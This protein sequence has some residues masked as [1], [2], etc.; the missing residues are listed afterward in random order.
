[1][2]RL[3]N[4]L[5]GI[6][7]RPYYLHQLDR[8]RGTGHFHVPV[9]TGLAMMDGLRGHLS[10][11]GVPHYMVDLPGGGGKI[12]PTPDYIVDKRAGYWVVRNYEG[13]HFNYPV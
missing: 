7:V 2:H 5:L 6:R 12:P 8:V 4:G 9:S 1:M 11:M 10:G 3:M 13:R